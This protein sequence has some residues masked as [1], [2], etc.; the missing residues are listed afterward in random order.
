MQSVPEQVSETAQPDWDALTTS[1]RD[2]SREMLHQ[3]RTGDWD[4]V[5]RMDAYR[6]ALIKTLFA[7]PIPQAMAP[8]VRTC[9]KE[10]LGDNNACTA[11]AQQEL[12]RLTKKLKTLAQ[13][14]KTQRAYAAYAPQGA[15]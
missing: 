10:I 13:R 14:R 3:A 4:S 5:R 12:G 7:Q 1:L 2:L 6:Q 11:L 9:I 8:D 15:R